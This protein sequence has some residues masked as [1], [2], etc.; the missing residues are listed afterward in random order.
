MALIFTRLSVRAPAAAFGC[1][2]SGSEAFFDG[3]DEGWDGLGCFVSLGCEALGSGRFGSLSL[4]AMS[5]RDSD[6]LRLEDIEFSGVVGSGLAS[7]E[8]EEDEL[9]AEAQHQVLQANRFLSNVHPPG[10]NLYKSW[11]TDTVSSSFAR[12]STM[13]PALGALIVTSIFENGDRLAFIVR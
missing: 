8:E 11:P 1:F 5:E 6:G 13:V 9:P 4:F 7:F 3:E 2:G 10:A 12:I